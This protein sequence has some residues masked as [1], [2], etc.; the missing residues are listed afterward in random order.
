V[1]TALSNG[2]FVLG[3]T[4][5]FGPGPG[6]NYLDGSGHSVRIQIFDENGQAAGGPQIVNDQLVGD[7]RL[8]S[9][10]ALANGGFVVNW[11]DLN[12]AGTDN[13]DVR[14]Q[15]FV[16][17][18][19]PGLPADVT[20]TSGGGGATA[21]VLAMENDVAVTIV[22]ATPAATSMQVQFAITGG[23]DAAKF[24]IDAT[25]GLVR[26]VATPDFEAPTDQGADNV[27]Q[28]VVTASDGTLSDSQAISVIVSNMNDAP[29]MASATTAFFALEN[30]VTAA[31]IAA[32]DLEGDALTYSIVSDFGGP[33]NAYYDSTKFNINPTTG[34]ITF[35]LFGIFE[36]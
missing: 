30:S 3:W 19:S 36:V 28:I 23:A 1:I 2:G 8:D 5:T 11:S 35:I 12:G 26:F 20:I 32:T 34:V 7:Q 18:P 29:V 31:T 15:V 25:T 21:T 17:D 16:V 13:D 4:T 33:L 14:A 9:I 6:I 27:Y 22:R 10:I 24:T